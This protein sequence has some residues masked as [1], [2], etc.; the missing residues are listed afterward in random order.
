MT[1]DIDTFIAGA[2]QQLADE[3][4]RA[5]IRADD[6]GL[7]KMVGAAFD[8]AEFTVA[9]EKNLAAGLVPVERFA[10][11]RDDRGRRTLDPVRVK[12]WGQLDAEQTAQLHAARARHIER[13]R[14]A[15]ADD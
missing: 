14:I 6:A 12:T 13:K 1:D 11:V 8:T 4:Q 7:H 10:L 9:Y 5:W 3:Q 2:R 15:A